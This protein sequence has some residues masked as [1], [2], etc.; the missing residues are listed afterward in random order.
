MF[1]TAPTAIRSLIKA[2]ETNAADASQALQARQPAPARLGG[3]ADQSCGVGVVPPARGRR[4][5]PDRRH[6]VADRDRRPHDHAAAGRDAAGAGFVHAAVPRHHRSDRRRDRRRRA[7]RARRH[8]GGQEAVAQHDPHD[9]GRPGAFQEELLP[10]RAQGLLPGR[11][12]REPRRRTRLLHDHRAHRRRAQRVGPPPGHDGDRV[13]AGGA[14][15][16]GGRSRR[17]GPA[18][19]H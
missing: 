15:R 16:A 12:R 8:P 1:Y 6:L 13:G 14:H 18:R 19:R 2:A 11:R 9:L 10:G 4:T 17:G 3:R 5:M 7:Q